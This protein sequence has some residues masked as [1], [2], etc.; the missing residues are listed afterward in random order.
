MSIVDVTLTPELWFHNQ[1]SPRKRDGCCR[2]PVK[3]LTW[4]Y[5]IDSPRHLCQPCLHQ[6]WEETWLPTCNLRWPTTTCSCRYGYSRLARWHW[7]CSKSTKT[8]PWTTWFTPCRGPTYPMRRSN[9]CSPRW[10]EKGFGI[11]SQFRTPRNIKVPVQSKTVC[12]LARHQQKHCMVC[13]SMLYL[14]KI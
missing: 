6:S 13:W 14:T 1:V 8:I 9:H 12:L 10:E 2:H 4:G 7:R 3:I 11:D 5:I